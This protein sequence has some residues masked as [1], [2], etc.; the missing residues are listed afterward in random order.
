MQFQLFNR[1]QFS[2]IH[3]L[4][5]FIERLQ[6]IRLWFVVGNNVQRFNVNEINEISQF[7]F[8]IFIVIIINIIVVCWW[9]CVWYERD[10]EF[11]SVAV[12]IQT[13]RLYFGT[14]RPER[15]RRQQRRVCQQLDA[16]GDV[17]ASRREHVT[18]GGRMHRVVH[19]QR[20]QSGT[21]APARRRLCVHARQWHWKRFEG[22]QWQRDTHPNRIAAGR[23]WSCRVHC[24]CH[25]QLRYTSCHHWTLFTT[26]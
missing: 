8:F 19:A 11:H 14:T 20:K 22:E 13:Q 4:T 21:Q 2:Q 24:H 12:D 3:E 5:G 17:V 15:L 7:L 25:V 23:A 6:E 10:E 1:N 18:I 9:W 16:G 26:T